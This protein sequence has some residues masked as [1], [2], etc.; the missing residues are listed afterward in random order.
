MKD[1]IQA[2]LAKSQLPAKVAV[3]K[4]DYT[5]WE[6]SSV[7]PFDVVYEKG[8]HV[9]CRATCVTNTSSSSGGTPEEFAL[10]APLANKWNKANRFSKLL[11]SEDLDILLVMDTDVRWLRADGFQAFLNNWLL[12]T[13]FFKMELRNWR[14][15]LGGAES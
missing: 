6:V 15:Q 2:V 12:Q 13:M 8:H 1:M 7:V 10:V 5:E 3:D 9:T 4:S 11:L 14:N